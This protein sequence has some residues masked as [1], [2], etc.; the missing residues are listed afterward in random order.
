M[1]WTRKDDFAP[2]LIDVI[3]IRLSDIIFNGFITPI[4]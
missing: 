3:A 2:K 1:I 4:T